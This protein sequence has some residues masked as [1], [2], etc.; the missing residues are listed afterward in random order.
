MLVNSNDYIIYRNQDGT[1]SLLLTGEGLPSNDLINLMNNL[2][3]ENKIPITA[4]I[5]PTILPSEPTPEMKMQGINEIS[6]KSGDLIITTKDGQTYTFKD[7]YGKIVNLEISGHF[8]NNISFSKET[9]PSIDQDNELDNY[10]RT[11]QESL[12][13]NSIFNHPKSSKSYTK[14]SSTELDSQSKTETEVINTNQTVVQNHQMAQN[15][16]NVFNEVANQKTE[17]SQNSIKE[18]DSSEISLDLED[19]AKQEQTILNAKHFTEK[20]KAKMIQELYQE[21]DNY[22]EENPEHHKT[23]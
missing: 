9:I 20:Q 11:Y 18:K 23:R 17:N 7:S 12:Q 13:R 8:E 3:E 21:F 6:I 2:K 22:V 1:Y 4:E 15:I 19:F 16:V 5:I 14:D 10:Y